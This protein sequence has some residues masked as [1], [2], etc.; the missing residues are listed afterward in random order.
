MQLK[1]VDSERLLP[2]PDVDSWEWLRS[3]LSLILMAKTKSKRERQTNRTIISI[4]GCLLVIA[5]ILS[6]LLQLIKECRR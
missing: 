1:K 4:L 2:E 3:Q 6:V 5:Q